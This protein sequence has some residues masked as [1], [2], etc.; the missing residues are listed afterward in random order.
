[1]SV[2]KNTQHPESTLKKKS[3]SICYHASRELVAMNES[4][5]AHISTN[6]NPADIASKIVGGGR[7]RTYL[8]GKLM[9]NIEDDRD[10]HLESVSK[11]RADGLEGF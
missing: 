9:H 7:K 10:E 1:M 5:M 11:S 6:E 3:N 2:I 8:I 4:R